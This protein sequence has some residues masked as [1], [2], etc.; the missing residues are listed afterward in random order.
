M[1]HSVEGRVVVVTGAAAGVG[2]AAV[3][4][5]AARG[6]DVALLAR[7]R[8]GLERAAQEVEALGRRALVLPLDV[9]DPDA[10]ERAAAD[11]ERKLGPIDVWVND[12]MVSVFA[13][14]LDIE[15]EEFRR[16][17]EVTYLGYVHGTRAALRRMIPRD[18]GTIV[19]VGSALAYRSIP[20][21]SAY[22]GAKHAIHG[23]CESIRTE[24]RHDKSHVHITEVQLPAV[25]TPQFAWSRA[26]LPGSPQ[27]VPPIFQPEVVADAIV[28]AAEHR[29]REIWLGWPSI[30]A[31][32]SDKIAPRLGDRYLAL[33]GFR[34]QQ[35]DEPI[36]PDRPD[37]LLR[38]VSGD[39]GARGQF[40]ARAKSY[41]VAWW[42]NKH[43]AAVGAG[44]AVALGGA[45]A[46]YTLTRAS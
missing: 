15:P 34:S 42:F 26:K 31:I 44:V 7:G 43:R 35:T 21:Q 1:K 24:L 5:F 19:Q 33:T 30:K 29:R 27:P 45:L 16:V 6:A 39:Y 40:D 25:N 36:R 8:D 9:A 17:T 46:A 20:L 10:V 23:L 32:V 11:V 12:A 28:Y 41:S 18:R 13:R 3:R 37:D 38:P 22:C 14:F 4:L 2:R